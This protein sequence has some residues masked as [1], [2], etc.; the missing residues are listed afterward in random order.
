M[1]WYAQKGEKSY[2]IDQFHRT[3]VPE[4]SNHAARGLIA[5]SNPSEMWLDETY[6]GISAN[7]FWNARVVILGA[8]PDFLPF[9]PDATR[10]GRAYAFPEAS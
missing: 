2:G 9:W 6:R 4:M 5:N 1:D 8:E 3:L 10:Q 7:K